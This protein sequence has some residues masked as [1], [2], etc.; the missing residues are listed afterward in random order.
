MCV[1]LNHS[2]NVD[3][4]RISPPPPRRKKERSIFLSLCLALTADPIP[5]KTFYGEFFSSCARVHTHK[6]RRW[7]R[8]RLGNSCSF[9]GQKIPA[10]S[11][12][13]QI[14]FFLFSGLF[15]F[16]WRY[17][18][19]TTDNNHHPLHITLLADFVEVE[20]TNE[21]RYFYREVAAVQS[22]AEYVKK[23]DRRRTKVFTF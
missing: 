20:Q 16:L 2:S 21:R 10:G 13:N 1:V 4:L 5:R 22:E 3:W 15:F 12:T 18:T 11:R 19:H 14:Q 7:M 17:F 9:D 8:K 23:W 6:T